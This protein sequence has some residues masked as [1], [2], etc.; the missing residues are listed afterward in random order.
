MTDDPEPA[1]ERAERAESAERARG[2]LT[3]PPDQRCVEHPDREAQLTCPRC[4]RHHCVPCFQLA[5]G[6]CEDCLRRNPADVA[7]PMPFEDRGRSLLL[8]VAATLATALQPARSAPAFAT[9]NLRDA[10]RFA[11]WTAVPLAMLSGIVP[12]TRTLMFAGAFEIQTIGTPDTLTI[13]LDVARAALIQVGLT[14]GYLLSLLLPYQSLLRANCGQPAAGY[15]LR[16]LMYRIW[17]E[18][19]GLLLMMLASYAA[20]PPTPSLDAATAAPSTLLAMAYTLKLLT[21]VLLML[22]MGF[23]ARLACGLSV[24]WA[25]IVVLVP[26]IISFFI[27]QAGY[28]LLEWLLPSPPQAN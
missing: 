24:L 6:I 18:P 1:S 9:D 4:K 12:H 26:V 17:L 20:I 22:A 15:G 19:F 5:L 8:R 27:G 11:L 25:V 14:G 13:A 2:P 23:T 10:L 21:E 7:P 16:V 28:E 3:A